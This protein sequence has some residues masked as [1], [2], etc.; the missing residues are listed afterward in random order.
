[1]EKV[2]EKMDSEVPQY[3]GK[4]GRLKKS[5]HP[6]LIASAYEHECSDTPI[7]LEHLHDVD[8]AHGIA[9]IEAG[10]VPSPHD[11][12][13]LKGLLDLKAIPESEFPLRPELGDLYNSKDTFLREKIGDVAG[14]IHCG[15]PRREALNLAFVLAT[16][17]R[18]L[19]LANAH[20]ALA[21]T[22]LNAA[23]KFKQVYMTDF[24]Y[25]HPAHPT[26]LGHYLMT[27]LFPILRD[28]ERLQR[29]FEKL[30]RCCAGS[31]S[32]NGSAL[33]FKRQRIAELLGFES[34]ST[35]T[36]DSM[37]QPDVPIEGMTVLNCLTMNLSRLGE[38]FQIWTTPPYSLV[39]FDDGLFRAS[40]IMPQKRNPYPMAYVRGLTGWL[41]GQM[42]SFTALGKT[43]SGNPDSRI[44]IYGDLPRATEK[45]IQAVTL[46][47]AILSTMKPDSDAMQANVDRSFGEATELAEALMRTNGVDYRI[48]HQIVGA[49]AAQLA[50]GGLSKSDISPELIAEISTNIVGTPVQIDKTQLSKAL[51][52]KSIVESR[53][54]TGGAAP[55]EVQRMIDEAATELDQ[56][57]RWIKAQE[58]RITAANARFE[59]ACKGITS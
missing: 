49:I 2:P 7:L 13:L 1:M 23:E 30:N 5:P 18:F 58:D 20:A 4:G 36:R 51:D 44:F 29:Y 41:S 14:W 57:Q 40:V 56:V 43:Y 39:D 21:R 31:G 24:T 55:V 22:F 11:K 50:E 48:T 52:T 42:A 10:V 9:L 34:V 8:I 16:R 35:H 25:M 15:R 17:A 37:W 59:E 28:F 45:T 33:P 19:E 27:F 3:F 6:A 12:A 38:E 32:S 54:E 53:T 46:F 47:D 26:S